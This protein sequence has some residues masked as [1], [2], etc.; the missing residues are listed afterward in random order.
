MQR[1]RIVSCV[2]TILL[3]MGVLIKINTRAVRV[4]V[5]RHVTPH[6]RVQVDPLSPFRRCQQL[7]DLLSVN[8]HDFAPYID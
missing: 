4:A 7:R 2:A 6:G 8:S 5:S 1:H 3:G